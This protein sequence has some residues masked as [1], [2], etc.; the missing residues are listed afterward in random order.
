MIA[1]LRASHFTP[2]L[3]QSGT[4]TSESGLAIPISLVEVS[5]NPRAMPRRHAPERRIPFTVLLNAPISAPSI[6]HGSCTLT[7]HDLSVKDLYIE[8]VVPQDESHEFAWYQIIL[9]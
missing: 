3:Q 4:M 6:L 2:L 9:N 7:I 1:T 8:R 5:E